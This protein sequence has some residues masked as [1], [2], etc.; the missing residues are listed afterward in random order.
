MAATQPKSNWIITPFVDLSCLSLG[1]L[2][3]FFIPYYFADHSETFRLLAV[4]TFAAH[5]YFTFPLIYLDPVE[6]Q[7]RKAI[8]LLTPVLCLAI[9]GLCYYFRIDEPEMFAI[10][11]LFNYF[12]FVR[13]KYGILRIYSGKARW[14]HKRLDAWTSYLWGIA[15]FAFMFGYQSD[16]E[17]RVMH[18]LRTLS[19]GTP[20]PM[21]MTWLAYLFA[22]L[23]TCVWLAYEFLNPEQ[24][25]W[26]KLI[27]LFSVVFM[28]GVVPILSTDALFIATSFSHA[29]EYIALVGF[30]VKNK[31]RQ[32]A[33][34]SPVL[35]R[36]ARHILLST[37]GFIIATSGMLYGLKTLSLLAFLVFTYGTSFM[38]FIFDGM[39]WKLRRPRVAQEVGVAVPG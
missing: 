33:F 38:H 12:H 19:G 35:A 20:I 2:A 27:F 30:T 1:W 15:G 18:Y 37:A 16:V 31:S 13:Q 23:I 21:E 39:I 3:F 17:G 34:E 7:R 11:Y 26:P 29:A 25:N 8:Y 4:T 9:V 22:S 5:R 14:G 24:K 36:A 10:W 28:Y 6:F 32:H